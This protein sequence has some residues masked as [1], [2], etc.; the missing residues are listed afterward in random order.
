VYNHTER[1]AQYKEICAASP[2]TP[3]GL[4]VPPTRR[5]R[6]SSRAAPVFPAGPRPCDNPTPHAIC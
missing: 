4:R 5:Q 2:R 1:L 3:R 6:A